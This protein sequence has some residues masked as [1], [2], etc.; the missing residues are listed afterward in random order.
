MYGTISEAASSFY[1]SNYQGY[2]ST[3]GSY[4]WTAKRLSR[5]GTNGR[6][7]LSAGVQ[8]LSV[9]VY[10]TK[11]VRVIV[12]KPKRVVVALR[13]GGGRPVYQVRNIPL[14]KQQDSSYIDKSGTPDISDRELQVLL[15]K[16]KDLP[17]F[18]SGNS[19]A[20]IYI[21]RYT[22]K[23]QKKVY[24]TV[25]I[26]YT[27]KVPKRV[28]V[29]VRK[30]IKM[31]TTLY[32]DQQPHQLSFESY[33]QENL[34][35]NASVSFTYDFPSDP[36]NNPVGHT[37]IIGR[38]AGQHANNVYFGTNESFSDQSTLYYNELHSRSLYNMASNARDGIA[39]IS[40][41]VAEREGLKRTISEWCVSTLSTLVKGKK[42]VADALIDKLSNPK[43]ISQLYLSY[44]YGLKPTI[45]DFAD[46]MRE[47]GKEAKT[48][49]KYKGTATKRW[50]QSYSFR[51]GPCVIQVN[52]KYRLSVKNQVLI[53]G[54][55]SHPSISNHMSINWLEAGWEVL[56]FSFVADWFAPIGAYL[57]SQDLFS[58]VQVK[59]WHETTFYTE[60]YEI[61]IN[62]SGKYAN[63]TFVGPV[64][65]FTGRKTVVNRV[66][67]D[68]QPTLP[69]P[70]FKSPIS[71]THVVNSIMLL[72]ANL[73]SR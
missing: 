23:W 52:R 24:K 67:R 51:N 3:N 58:D 28:I 41:I 59:A 66:V 63:F 4:N 16:R 14:R 44:I 37:E 61:I 1:A 57:A 45:Q 60:E 42:A 8:R 18:R 31:P 2:N 20:Q 46:L 15:N 29:S 49:R 32:P 17:N 39:N 5:S 48:W 40:N 71:R 56:P 68:G 19:I 36:H 13:E 54:S 9:P 73:K 65:S 10:R 25:M 30:V 27:K 62:H 70:Q 21:A 35:S 64:Q 53:T 12:N 7:T 55:D 50:E 69:S 22:R 11:W 47:L 33:I 34:N 26:P 72:I 6:S 43:K 38:V